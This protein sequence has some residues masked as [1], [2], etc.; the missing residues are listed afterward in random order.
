MKA[1]SRLSLLQIATCNLQSEILVV[2][3]S[4]LKLLDFVSGF[5]FECLETSGF[6]GFFKRQ[7]SHREVHFMLIRSVMVFIRLMV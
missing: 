2:V 3:Y 4:G 5:S 7:Q 6:R 1:D